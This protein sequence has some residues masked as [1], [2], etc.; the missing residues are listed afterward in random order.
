MLDQ[1]NDRISKV[2][3]NFD[4]HGAVFKTHSLKPLKSID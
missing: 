4:T 2:M 3:G 1:K